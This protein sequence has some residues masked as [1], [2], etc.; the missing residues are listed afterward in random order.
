M[1]SLLLLTVVFCTFAT[2]ALAARLVYLKD[3]GTI[4]AKSVWRTKGT[5]H[6]LVNRDTLTEFSTAEIDMKRTFARKRH[7]V[8]KQTAPQTPA[9]AQQTQPSGTSTPTP[10]KQAEDRKK[11]SLPRLPD[12][13]DK[14]PEN[15]VP[16]S[17]S[18]GA[19]KKHKKE[20]AE[21]LGE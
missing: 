12:L 16:S 18:G 7:V 14:S 9:T 3:G 11:L 1:R 8:R 15:L 2:P 6:V 17:G 10:A 21:K 5:V 4:K 13:A 19:I 20:M